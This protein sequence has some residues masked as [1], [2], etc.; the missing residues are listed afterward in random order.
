MTRTI[1]QPATDSSLASAV[2]REQLQD[3]ENEIASPSSINPGHLHTPA[4]VNATGTPS[5]STFWR[6]DN[7]WAAPAGTSLL[8][9]TP[10]GTVDGSNT[11]FTVVHSPA[12]VIVDGLVR[13]LVN[14]ITDLN[15]N[16]YTYSTGVLTVN[17]AVPPMSFIRS[18]YNG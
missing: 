2:V 1:T 3:L 9:E 6:G 14:T 7:T 17:S 5:S 12:Y 18:F 15:G 16:G 11:V 10:S 13:V 4:G 8:M